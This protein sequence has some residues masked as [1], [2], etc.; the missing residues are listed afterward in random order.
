MPFV[1]LEML[2]GRTFEQKKALV[3]ELTAVISKH[4]G[5]P[6]EAIHIILRDIPRG[7]GLA[8]GGKFRD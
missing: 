6:T 2:E 7:D 1:H 4:T 3:E 5:A 8:Q